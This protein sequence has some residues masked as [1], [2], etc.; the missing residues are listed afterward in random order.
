MERNP[1]TLESL[2]VT[3]QVAEALDSE[4]NSVPVVSASI[5]PVDKSGAL[6][7]AR[8]RRPTRKQRRQQVLVL[9]ATE[10]A[11]LGSS[12]KKAK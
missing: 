8:Q 7:R 11:M 10:R 2:I 3:R 1:I 9:M 6:S 12:A 4:Q 5:S